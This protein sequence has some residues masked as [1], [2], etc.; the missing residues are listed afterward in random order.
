MT[1]LV[2]YAY[3][4]Q[5][6]AWIPPYRFAYTCIYGEVVEYDLELGGV[7][8][9]ATGCQAVIGHAGGLLVHELGSAYTAYAS[10]DDLAA[11]TGT[12]MVLSLDDDLLLA[13]DGLTLYGAWFSTDTLSRVE[14][15]SGYSGPELVLDGF[16]ARVAG[17]DAAPDAIRVVGEDGIRAFD[18]RTGALLELLPTPSLNGLA[19]VRP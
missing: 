14:L 19:V 2:D 5:N 9:A 1:P 11:G 16:D 3:V 15:A 7:R 6:L 8:S 10:F 4:H 12:P 17:L 13:S 18:P